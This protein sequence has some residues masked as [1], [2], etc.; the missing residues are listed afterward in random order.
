MSSGP[1]ARVNRKS[2]LLFGDVNDLFVGVRLLTSS[3]ESILGP[4]AK[5][6]CLNNGCDWFIERQDSGEL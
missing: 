3:K 4:I 2:Q 5:Q 1:S 6:Q